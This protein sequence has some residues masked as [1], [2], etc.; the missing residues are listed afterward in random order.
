[1][2]P[3]ELTI[4]E[5]SLED[6]EAIS[7][8][9]IRTYVD[10]WGREFAPDDLVWHLERTV[11]PQRWREHLVHDRVLCAWLDG[12]PV[13]FVQFGPGKGPRR[14]TIDRLYVERACQGQ[15]I[16]SDLLRRALAEPEVATAEVV[17]I[18]VWQDN[19][20]ARRLYERFGF[21]DEGGRV[22]FVL[23]SGKI[24]GYD[25]I[26]VLRRLPV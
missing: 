17:T 21:R 4:A 2:L 25:H 11:S 6:A 8:L 22:P 14:M 23:Q 7:A 18:D 26:L 24:G 16:G 12:H 3:M 19:P 10:T 13:G 1:M 20:G 15:G 5:A 9:A